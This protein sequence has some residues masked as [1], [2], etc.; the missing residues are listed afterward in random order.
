[1]ILNKVMC[2]WLTLTT[3]DE[4]IGFNWSRHML[5]SGDRTTEAKRMQYKGV[6]L[7]GLFAGE[8]VQ[9]GKRHFMLQASGEV[10]DRVLRETGGFDP[11]LNCTRIDL[12][13]TVDKPDGFDSRS[14]Y[15]AIEAWEASGRARQCSV[16]QSGDGCDTVYIGNRAS[17]RFTRLYV[18]PTTEGHAL[19]FETE[20]K[21]DHAKSLFKKCANEPKEMKRAI[22]GELKSLP[23]L[24]NGLLDR[25]LRVTGHGS[26]R[27]KPKR[28]YAATGGLR[29]LRDQVTPAI[30]RMMN[31][32][33][34]GPVVR[35]MVRA[36]AAE[37]D[38]ID[39]P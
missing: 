13:V 32:H 3:F 28:R 38:Q 5:R 11:R 14:V 29:W 4:S 27:S 8:G 20:Y 30:M 39:P 21:G 22:T 24:Q 6:Q 35:R 16:V 34:I 31:D 1:M 26:R 10:A 19:R 23:E 25:F 7:D 15:D 18:K 12:Q 36:W 2:D 37:A 33:E 17:D 9:Q